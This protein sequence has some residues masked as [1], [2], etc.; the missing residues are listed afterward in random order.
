VWWAEPD[1]GIHPRF[2]LD[3]YF[4]ALGIGPLWVQGVVAHGPA[5]RQL[6]VT[7]SRRESATA[8][9]DIASVIA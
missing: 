8:G 3:F 4:E 6:L 5:D 1:H 7:P 2:A 9:K